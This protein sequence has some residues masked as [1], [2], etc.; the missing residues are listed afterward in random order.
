M[1]GRAVVIGSVGL[2][3]VASSPDAD[4]A[5][6]AVGNSGSNIAIRLAAAGWQ[7]TFVTVVGA[8]EAGRLVREDCE[9]WGVSTRSFFIDPQYPTP[10]VFIVSDGTTA[11][12]LLFTCPACGRRALPLRIPREDQLGPQAIEDATAADLII[13]DIP[14]PAAARLAGACRVGLVWYEASM[15]EAG[16]S[17]QRQLAAHADV[18]KCSRE[19]AGHYAALFA[20]PDPRTRV[21]IVTAGSAGVDA[22]LRV[23]AQP[24]D[25]GAACPQGREPRPGWQRLHVAASPVSLVDPLGAGDAFTSAAAASLAS[26]R[27]AGSRLTA[28]ELAA[29]MT[30]GAASA[31]T[32]CGAVGTRG[33]MTNTAA[34]TVKPCIADDVPFRC[35][36]C[37]P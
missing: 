6:A 31:A 36:R 23:D 34:A 16:P 5:T 4:S 7:V 24:G 22:E 13:A 18:L 37:A 19:E 14:G 11:S 27:V 30:A 3:L 15:F 29:A 2:D 28:G 32:A 26:A 33:D 20:A 25:D 8:D 17:D 9:R 10:R 1:T 35:A 21:K 12:R